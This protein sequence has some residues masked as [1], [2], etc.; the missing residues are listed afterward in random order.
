[1]TLTS[2]G[3]FV[4]I[5]SS[6]R[7]QVSSGVTGIYIKNNELFIG[8]DVI[9]LELDKTMGSLNMLYSTKKRYNVRLSDGKYIKYIK[10]ECDVSKIRK[11]HFGNNLTNIGVFAFSRYY[12]LES[13]TIPDS[14]TSLSGTIFSWD[15][16]LKSVYIP[17]SVIYFG[18]SSFW[19]C[20]NLEKVRLSE[21][22]NYTKLSKEMFVGCKRLKELVLPANITEIGDM[23]FKNCS[24]LQNLICE[25]NTV[26]LGKD[27]F[28]G[29]SKLKQVKVSID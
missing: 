11:V 24:N 1:M 18:E 28:K 15:K 4:F 6:N 10:F 27:V 20:I 17:D 22:P 5:I 12:S 8:D 14:V 26:S 2:D 25:G 9:S 21:N 7:H 29:C 19:Q 16:S 3:R 23:V 13:I